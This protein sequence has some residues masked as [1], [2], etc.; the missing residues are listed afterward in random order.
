MTRFEAFIFMSDEKAKCSLSI[1]E[2]LVVELSRD[3]RRFC[4]HSN[5]QALCY[6]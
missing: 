3:V 2:E 1:R 6:G 4:L 5:N